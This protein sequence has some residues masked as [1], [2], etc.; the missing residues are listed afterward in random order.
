MYKKVRS[1]GRYMLP[2]CYLLCYL[3]E[4]DFSFI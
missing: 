2:V 4:S 3:S 1:D